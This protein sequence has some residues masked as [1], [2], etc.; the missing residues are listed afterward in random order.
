[1]FP[2]MFLLVLLDGVLDG[3]SKV[4]LFIVKIYILIWYFWVSLE[5]YSMPMLSIRGNN[6]IAH[7]AYD[8]LISSHVEHTRKEF[9]RM[10]SQ[11]YNENSFHMYIHAEHT[12]NE[13][14]RTLSIH[15]TNFI[16]GWAYAEWISSLAEHTRKKMF[17][18]R[19]YRA[20]PIRFSTIVCYW[21]LGP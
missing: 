5:N 15:G 3:F 7:W 19:I 10:L 14:H 20:N 18:S 17:K 8:E 2:K 16:D 21:S 6:F 13:F 1:M 12:Q 4:W 9:S 11:R